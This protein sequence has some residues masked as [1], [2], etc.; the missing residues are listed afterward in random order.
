MSMTIPVADAVAN[1][2]DDD[3][4]EDAA[5]MTVSHYNYADNYFEMTVCTLEYSARNA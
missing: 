1:D 3:D 5:K 2:N 4:D